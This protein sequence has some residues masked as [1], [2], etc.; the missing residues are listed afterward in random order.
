MH[1]AK[2][3]IKLTTMKKLLAYESHHFIINNCIPIYTKSLQSKGMVLVWL[4][5]LSPHNHANI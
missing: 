5:K 1:H 3:D 2:K 4:V